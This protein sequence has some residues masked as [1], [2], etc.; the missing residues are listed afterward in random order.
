[1]SP[2]PK[3]SSVLQHYKIYQAHEHREHKPSTTFRGWRSVWLRVSMWK[4]FWAFQI[5]RL[6]F[7]GRTTCKGRRDGPLYDL[8]SRSLT[9]SHSHPHIHTCKHAHK[10]THTP[11]PAVARGKCGPQILAVFFQLLPLSLQF[12]L[13]RRRGQK[14]TNNVILEVLAHLPKVDRCNT[15]KYITCTYIQVN[16]C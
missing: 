16:T 7:T 4:I 5:R 2:A 1:M 11:H 9:P 6:R 8:I 12:C 10:H 13:S 3:E 15:Y 14:V